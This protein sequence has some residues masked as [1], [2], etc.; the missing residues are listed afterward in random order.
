MCRKSWMNLQNWIC[1]KKGERLRSLA[2]F[3]DI[4]LQN[5]YNVRW[6]KS[7]PFL[8]EEKEGVWIAAWIG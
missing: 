7:S 1:D 5:R 8:E 6:C 2:L 4:V 3:L